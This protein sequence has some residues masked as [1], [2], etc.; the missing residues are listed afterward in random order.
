MNMLLL[1]T[2][3]LHAI[4]DLKLKEKIP[5]IRDVSDILLRGQIYDTEY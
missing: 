2:Y 4:K 5:N 1:L 3:N